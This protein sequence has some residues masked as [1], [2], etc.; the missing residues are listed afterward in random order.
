MFVYV[1]GSFEREA[2]MKPIILKQRKS[3]W[4]GTRKHMLAPSGLQLPAA[5]DRQ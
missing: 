2:R 3:R 5:I 1:D 4:A